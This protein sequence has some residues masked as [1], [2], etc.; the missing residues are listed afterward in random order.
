MVVKLKLLG[1]GLVLLAAA[2]LAF[3]RGLPWHSGRV[4]S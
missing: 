2:V 1:M 3:L 4:S